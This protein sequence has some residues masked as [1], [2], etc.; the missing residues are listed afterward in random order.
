MAGQLEAERKLMGDEFPQED[1][2]GL[3]PALH[4]R[5]VVLGE[6]VG[7]ERGTARRA[8]P[9]C[10]VDVFVSDRDAQERTRIAALQRGLG[11]VRVCHGA[12]SRQGDEGV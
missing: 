3:L 4:T 6:P 7:E 11:G 10:A 2:A 5:R 8:D 12:V 1:G 9:A